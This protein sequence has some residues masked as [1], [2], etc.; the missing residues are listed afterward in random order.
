[1]V[2]MLTIVIGIVINDGPMMRCP[3]N[4]SSFSS[5]HQFLSTTSWR[6]NALEF[7]FCLSEAFVCHLSMVCNSLDVFIVKEL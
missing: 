3:S 5:S 1:M 2:I 6:T 7:K 4:P